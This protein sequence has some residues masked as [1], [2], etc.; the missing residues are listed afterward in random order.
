MKADALRTLIEEMDLL[1]KR[2]DDAN[3]ARHKIR[4]KEQK[5]VVSN[6]IFGRLITMT[7]GKPPKFVAFT[8]EETIMIAD[9]LDSAAA[10]YRDRARQVQTKI[11]G[12]EVI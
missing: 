12:A 6:G 8:D 2:A 5:P 1:N 10:R 3:L 4:W 7:Q 9:A 11:E